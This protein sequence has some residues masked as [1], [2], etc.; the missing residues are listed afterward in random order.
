M[1]QADLGMEAEMKQARI[2]ALERVGEVSF[3]IETLIRLASAFRVG[4]SVK[5]VP[6]SEMLNWENDFVPDEFDV[7]PIEKDETFLRPNHSETQ[8]SISS[9][10]AAAMLGKQD[11]VFNR[12]STYPTINEFEPSL[13]SGSSLDSRIRETEDRYTSEMK[14]PIGSAT[15]GATLNQSTQEQG[16]AA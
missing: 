12:T 14:M 2:S 13:F 11:N 1:K 3:S 10:L 7:V 5:F 16:R 4:L 9:G 8:R 6:M 15:Q